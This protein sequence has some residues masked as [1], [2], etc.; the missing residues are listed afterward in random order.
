MSRP[1]IYFVRSF[2]RPPSFNDSFSYLYHHRCNF[3]LSQSQSLNF[4][5]VDNVD[6]S[7]LNRTITIK[8]KQKHKGERLSKVKTLL[9]SLAGLAI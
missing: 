9:F 6:C 2:A 7:F 4:C 1:A 5:C 3:S 8:V